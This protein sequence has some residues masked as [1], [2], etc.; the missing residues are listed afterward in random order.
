MSTRILHVVANADDAARA[1]ATPPAAAAAWPTSLVAAWKVLEAAG[2]EQLLVSPAG[3]AVAADTSDADVQG[4]VA[5][6]MHAVLLA[7]T[8]APAQIDAGDFDAVVCVA[9]D[10]DAAAATLHA[11]PGLERIARSVASHGGVVAAIGHADCALA[12]SADAARAVTG[13]DARI[14]TGALADADDRAA[15]S[16]AGTIAERVATLLA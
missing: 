9:S 10:A 13:A 11:S 16:A 2:F 3:G 5:D 14:V 8:A 7:H 12:E 1:A 15:A 4:W 6:P